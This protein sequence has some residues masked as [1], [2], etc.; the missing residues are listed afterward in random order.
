M[1]SPLLYT[2][3]THDCTPFHSSNSILKFADNTAVV[4]LITEGDETAYRDRDEVNKLVLWCTDN[5]L[6]L[7]TLK[8]KEIIVDFRRNRPDTLPTY[9]NGVCVEN[10]SDFKYLGL[11]LDHN[12]SWK[13]NTIALVKKA[14]Q[15]LHFLRVLKKQ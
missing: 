8:T 6:A 13:T 4:G 5:N 9:I 7:N 12:I 1:L 14:Q 2:F 10:V 3:Y 11:H 15:R